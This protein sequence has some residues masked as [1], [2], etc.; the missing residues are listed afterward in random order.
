MAQGIRAL[1]PGLGAAVPK[2]PSSV[3]FPAKPTEIIDY[4]SNTLLI[5]K[6]SIITYPL[7]TCNISA[8]FINKFYFI[9][10]T[11]LSIIF[12]AAIRSAG[13]LWSMRSTYWHIY[14]FLYYIC[15]SNYRRICDRAADAY[16]ESCE[17]IVCAEREMYI[18][19]KYLVVFRG[20]AS[21]FA[22]AFRLL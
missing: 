11:S 13:H 6:Q 2:P 10:C 7:F 19:N 5:C 18:Y 9:I 20:N 1:W 15:R 16:F 21:S 3:T 17:Y 4:P 22:S 8:I 14:T 12:I